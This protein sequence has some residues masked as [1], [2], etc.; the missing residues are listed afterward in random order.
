MRKGHSRQ[1]SIN[2]NHFDIEL[3]LDMRWQFKNFVAGRSGLRSRFCE[4]F[5]WHIQGRHCGI[6]FSSYWWNALR[7]VAHHM[8]SST[9]SGFC[10][11]I[12]LICSFSFP[13]QQTPKELYYFMISLSPMRIY[14]ILSWG[15][16]STLA[17]LASYICL[18]HEFIYFY[19]LYI[20][21]KCWYRSF[22]QYPSRKGTFVTKYFWL[23]K[24]YIDGFTL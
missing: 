21:F 9:S 24:W 12:W 3:S 13:L 16:D 5:T 4:H 20:C 18:G 7:W 19:W 17:I 14:M 2:V 22:L 6:C 23:H 11:I 10:Y 8:C 1:F 15:K